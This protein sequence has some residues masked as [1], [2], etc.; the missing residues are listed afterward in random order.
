MAEFL[1]FKWQ[2]AALLIPINSAMRLLIASLLFCSIAVAQEV[3]PALPA[4]PAPTP[5][6]DEIAKFLAGYPLPPG[7]VLL[8]LQESPQ[9]QAHAAAFEKMWS[10]YNEHYFTPMRAWSA[11][12]LSPR[13][14]STAPLFY[15]FSGPDALGALAFFPSAND[16]LLGGL[17]PVGNLPT[18]WTL[19]AEHLAPALENLRTSTDVILN[20]GHFITK[21]MKSDLTT[22]E[23]RGVLPVL[24]T[25]LAMTGAEV[26]DVCFFGVDKNGAVQETGLSPSGEGL[27]PGVRV[28]FRRD[29]LSGP[30]RIHYVQANVADDSLSRGLLTWAGGFGKGNVYL[31]A[32][33]YLLHENFFSKIRTFLLDQAVSVLQDDSGIPLPFFLNGDWRCWFFGTYTGTLDIFKKYEQPQLADAMRL[34]ASPLPFGTG[35]KWR[36]GESNLLLAIREAPLR[37]EPVIAPY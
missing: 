11:A 18:P 10:R 8:R 25:F 7:S 20:F 30:Q 34:Q 22:S 35:Y 4:N 15:F 23:F 28:T 37:A 27:L 9:G 29:A 33:S 17:E 32:A 19:P 2:K 16:Y 5:G 13:I 12:E 6:W 31:K 26:L 3:R 21:E 24:M 1:D 14:P 36:L